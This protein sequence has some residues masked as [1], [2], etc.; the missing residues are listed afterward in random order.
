MKTLSAF[1]QTES[2]TK[3]VHRFFFPHEI[4]QTLG[5]HFCGKAASE[6][7]RADFD[8]TKSHRTQQKHRCR[9]SLHRDGVMNVSLDIYHF[10]II[11]Y[12]T[13]H[14]DMLR[15][16]SEWVRGF[17]TS[18]SITKIPGCRLWNCFFM[19]RM[20]NS[21][22]S[23]LKTVSAST[24]SPANSHKHMIASKQVDNNIFQK[25]FPLAYYY[26]YLC[27]QNIYEDKILWSRKCMNLIAELI[28]Y[29]SL[30]SSFLSSFE[31]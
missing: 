1:H 4:F 26:C 7:I 5:N 27:K 13:R 2:F 29:V 9:L 21:Q 23:T 8:F 12:L 10:E 24:S 11:S 31:S 25:H 14:A 15:R 20:K 17:K 22:S 16:K 3:T 28:F 18:F 30:L 19:R 6:W